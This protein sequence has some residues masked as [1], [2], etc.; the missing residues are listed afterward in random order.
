MTRA[1]KAR[2]E[3]RAEIYTLQRQYIALHPEESYQIALD[4]CDLISSRTTSA[5]L[6]EWRDTLKNL[7]DKD[8]KRT[9][10]ALPRLRPRRK[11]SKPKSTKRKPRR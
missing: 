3:L 7:L 9:P 1:S 11:P 10:V 4:S 2:E 5:G 8:A 6:I